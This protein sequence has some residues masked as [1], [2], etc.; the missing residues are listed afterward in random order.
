MG[1][2]LAEEEEEQGVPAAPVVG[3]EVHVD[4]PAAPAPVDLVAAVPADAAASSSGD[5]AP[6][7]PPPPALHPLQ[8]DRAPRGQRQGLGAAARQQWDK[9]YHDESGGYLRLSLTAGKEHWDIRAVCGRHDGCTLTKRCKPGGEFGATAARGRPLGLLWAFLQASTDY[10]TKEEHRNRVGEWGTHPKRAEARRLFALCPG[11]HEFLSKERA[12]WP[13][14][15]AGSEPA[16][17]A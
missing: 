9:I 6:P 5:V 1:Q 4:P 16:G 12:T 14:E 11:A 2:V 13:H 15:S 8:P 10:P 7:P 3:E 17:L